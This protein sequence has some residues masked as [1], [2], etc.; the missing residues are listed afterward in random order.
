VSEIIVVADGQCRRDIADELRSLG[1]ILEILPT[2]SG[3]NAARQRGVELA[4]SEFIAFLDDDDT[5]RDDKIERQLQLLTDCDSSELPVLYTAVS[6]TRGRR[7][8]TRPTRFPAHGQRIQEYLFVRRDFNPGSAY[9]STSTLVTRRRTL[10]EHPLSSGLKRHQDWDWLI[11]VAEAHPERLAV[12]VHPVPLTTIRLDHAHGISASP[13]WVSSLNWARSIRRHLSPREYADLLMVVS[14]SIA[15]RGGSFDGLL[16][17]ATEAWTHGQPSWRGLVTMCGFA[18]A[19]GPFR[20]WV[21]TLT[22]R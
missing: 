4:G 14:A 19:P 3:A 11:R 15:G 16:R 1:I 13:D 8:I 22:P 7:T 2:R 21:S 6:A 20:R 10:Q 12:R 18:A 5:W 17:I 9:L